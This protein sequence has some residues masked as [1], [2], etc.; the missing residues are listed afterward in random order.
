MWTCDSATRGGF[1]RSLGM[2]VRPAASNSSTSAA[3]SPDVIFICWAISSETMFTTNSRVA[4]MLRSVSLSGSGPD[5]LVGQKQITGGFA[6]IAVKKLKG[7][8]FRMPSQLIV[9]TKQS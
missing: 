5:F 6:L 2:G 8:R 7:A 9:E 3:K 4:D 1:T